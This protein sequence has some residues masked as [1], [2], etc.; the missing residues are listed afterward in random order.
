V[1]FNI[2]NNHTHRVVVVYSFISSLKPYIFGMLLKCF[3]ISVHAQF[4]HGCV[5]TRCNKSRRHA[6][7][8]TGTRTAF[9]MGHTY[10]HQYYIY[11]MKQNCQPNI[12]GNTNKCALRSVSNLGITTNKRTEIYMR[13]YNETWILHF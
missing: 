10:K 9:K 3:S 12:C 8:I 1:V 13:Q 11:S 7:H 2:L 5:H 4:S 6:G